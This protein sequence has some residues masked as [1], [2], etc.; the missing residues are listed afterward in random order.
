LTYEVEHAL[1]PRMI[2]VW[3][4][5][6]WFSNDATRVQAQNILRDKQEGTFLVRYFKSQRQRTD[7]RGATAR[8]TLLCKRHAVR[9]ALPTAQPTLELCPCAAEASLGVNLLDSGLG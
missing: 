7:R 8:K 9:A 4:D 5:S 2:D 1:S 6:L 3:D